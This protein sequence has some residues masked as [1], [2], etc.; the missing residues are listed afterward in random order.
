MR[1]ILAIY[2]KEI[3]DAMRDRRTLMMV[4]ASSLLLVPVLLFVFSTVMS[5]VESQAVDRTVMVV[6][7]KDAPSL[8]NYIL[9]QGYQI[10]Q[11]PADYEEKSRNKELTKPVLLIPENFENSLAQAKRVELEIAYDTSNRQAE[12][13]L[14]PLRRL[15]NGY[16]QE[17]SGL[18]LMMRGI[19]PDLLQ[20]ITVKERHISRPDERKVT[21]TG[22]LP[23]VLIMAIVMGGMFAAIDSTAGERERGS[24]E[25]L[26]M[27]PV[28][29]LQVA[30]GKTAAVASVSVLIVILTV[31]SFF[32]AQSV[33]ANEALRAEFQFG[34]KD[35]LAFLVVLLPL[36]AALSSL[37]V[38]LSLTCK[39]FKE[40]NVR[41]QLLSLTVSF[42]PLFFILNPG[43]EPAWLGWV[44]VMAQTQMMNQVLKGELVSLNSIA[45]ALLVCTGIVIASLSF[46]SKKMRQVVME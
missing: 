4:L 12:M 22:M 36:A 18:D 8:E 6:N 16:V 23:M 34:V 29:G 44:P 19:S 1:E 25:P 46:V 45:I 24:L 11:A 40:A 38:A 41:N 9:R 7:M 13:G 10:K 43:K 32:P 15:L 27:N 31:S 5:Q 17:R 30:V 37:Q 39:T 2:W 33:I 21:I 3:S 14:G 28:S 42:L 26:M 20:T 35:A